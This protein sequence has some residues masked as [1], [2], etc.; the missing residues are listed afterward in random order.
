MNVG[1]VADA[2]HQGRLAHVGSTNHR[3]E[4]P[5]HGC[6]L[7]RWHELAAHGHELHGGQARVELLVVENPATSV[8]EPQVETLVTP[9]AVHGLDGREGLALAQDITGARRALVGER[10]DGDALRRDD[11]LALLHPLQGAP[12]L[13]DASLLRR[14]LQS[15]VAGILILK[16]GGDRI[17]TLC[18]PRSHA[19]GDLEVVVEQGQLLGIDL[20]GLIHPLRRV[21]HAVED[22][23]LPEVEVVA[24]LNVDAHGH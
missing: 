10:A 21:I 4:R 20:L 15:D 12:V 16:A 23:A 11:V 8:R 5:L 9:L 14:R 24:V 6:H 1:D 3:D 18:P 17:G 2:I 7:V 22:G 13:P 19:R